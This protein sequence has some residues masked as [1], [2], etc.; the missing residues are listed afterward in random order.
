VILRLARW[1]LRAE[2]KRLEGLMFVGGFCRSLSLRLD[3]VLVAL[4]VLK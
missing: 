1:A 4:E 2:K 3:A